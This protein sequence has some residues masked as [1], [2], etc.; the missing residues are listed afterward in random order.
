SRPPNSQELSPSAVA[1]RSRDSAPFRTAVSP[2]ADCTDVGSMMLGLTASSRFVLTVSQ[3]V[4]TEAPMS[5]VAPARP[6]F[7]RNLMR[8]GLRSEAKVDSELE[9]RRLRE[10]LELAGRIA[11]ARRREV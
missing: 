4:R 9:Q 8:S 3:A 10:R 6:F 1:L 5:G 11:T 7:S 2:A